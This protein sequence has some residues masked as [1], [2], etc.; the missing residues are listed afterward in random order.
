M[1]DKK[2]NGLLSLLDQ[3]C[4]LMEPSVKNFTENFLCAWSGSKKNAV[5]R[6]KIAN[7]FII[8]HFSGPV[9]YSTVS[10]FGRATY[11]IL[12]IICFNLHMFQFFRP[13]SSKK[14]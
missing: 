3:Q 2:L 6:T 4:I 14:I 9:I 5:N 10:N 11:Y 7:E 1:F 12:Y 13:I 8:R